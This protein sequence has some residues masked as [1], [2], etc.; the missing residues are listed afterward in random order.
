MAGAF[1]VGAYEFPKTSSMTLEVEQC[2]EP[3]K[4]K[5]TI[6]RPDYPRFSSSTN[7]SKSSSR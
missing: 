2:A 4:C 3:T 5:K 6:N 7:F 1:R